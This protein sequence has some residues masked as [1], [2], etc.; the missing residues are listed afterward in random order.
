MAQLRIHNN[1]TGVRIPRTRLSRLADL[2][3]HGQGVA[4]S[5]DLILVA[6]DAMRRLNRRYRKKDKTTD[7]LSFS[8]EDDADPLL[9]EIYISLPEARRNATQYQRRLNEELL[10]LLAHGLLH[11]CGVHHADAKARVY[12]KGLEDRYLTRL[13]KS[14]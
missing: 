14:T 2:V 11:L 4:K 7:V 10:Q 6:D 13:K 8:L 5:V 3:L 1:C 9:G 12:M